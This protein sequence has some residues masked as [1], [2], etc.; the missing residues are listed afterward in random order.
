M[1]SRPSWPADFRP[2]AACDTVELAWIG[3]RTPN[4]RA[5]VQCTFGR[6]LKMGDLSNLPLECLRSLLDLTDDAACLVDG[7]SWQIMYANSRL[8]RLTGASPAVLASTNLF[9][10]VPELE[11]ADARLQLAELAAAKIDSAQIEL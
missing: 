2:A 8:I 10:L 7:K 6:L 1:T 9:E 11:Q 3:Q 4:D 5:I